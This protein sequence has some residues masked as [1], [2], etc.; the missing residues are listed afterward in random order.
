MLNGT[1]KHSIQNP[2]SS[3]DSI[4]D[5]TTQVAR[6][7][8]VATIAWNDLGVGEHRI[9]CPKC[10]RGGRDRTCGVKMEA[11][12]NGVSH[13][14]RCGYVESFNTNHVAV[15]SRESARSTAIQKVLKHTRLNDGGAA[16]WNSTQELRGV[17]LQ[18]LHAR[19]CAIPPQDS[20]LRYHPSLKHP[21]G[22]VGPSL[23]ALITN[24]HTREPLSL[25]RTWITPTGKKD[26]GHQARL[27]LGNHSTK[28]GVIRLY[29]D[30]WV[31][32]WLGIAEGIETALSL[33]WAYQPVWA[34]I[35][36]GH[37]AQFPVLDGVGDL[38]IA[39]D[40]D[41]AGISAAAFCAQRWV[42]AG[43]RVL[44]TNQIENDLNDVLR[45]AS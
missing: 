6:N 10:G 1:C 28:D 27:L 11:G 9:E 13:C 40:Q 12:G 18:Y 14:F 19:R 22:Y 23:V 16:L 3:W 33:A 37:L 26:L 20:D 42:D 44:V 36:A 43:R 17:A 35:D 8:E 41:P 7:A 31:T 4:S 25:H 34:T 45:V 5:R 21:S 15:K 29:P 39:R 30:D 24:V 32:S 2:P 38:V